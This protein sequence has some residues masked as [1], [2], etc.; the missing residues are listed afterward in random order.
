[1]KISHSFLQL[2]SD[3]G[4]QTAP[5]PVSNPQLLLW[6]AELA[7]EL[8][9]PDYLNDNAALFL[10]G[11]Q[12]LPGSQPLAQAYAGHQF[13]SYNPAL[14]DG[15]AHLIAELEAPSGQTIDLQ[16]KGSGQTR[17][18][19]RGDGRC[20]IGPAIREF[21]MSEAMH[22]LGV[23]TTRTLAV[24]TSGETVLR[25]TPQAGAIVSRVADSHLRVGTF[26]YHCYSGNR[27]NL[28]ALLDYTIQRHYPEIGTDDDNRAIALLKAVIKKQIELVVEWMRVGFI[29]GV[30]N[31]DNTALSGQTIDFGPCAMLGIY[32][33]NTAYSAIDSYGR[34][35]FG[36]QPAIT[37][38]NLA[39]FAESLLPLIDP[40]NEKALAQAVPIIEGFA[41]QYYQA[42]YRMMAGKLGLPR[43]DRQLTD[44]LLAEMEQGQ[45]D[46][47]DTFIKLMQAVDSGESPYGG[48][49][50]HWF[51]RWQKQLHHNSLA[52][53][54]RYN[55]LV[56]PRNHHMERVIAD[57]S[58]NNSSAAADAFL[59]V[60]R[61]PYKLTPQTSAYQDLPADGDRNYQTFCGT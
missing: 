56:I 48:S 21:I 51:A 3:F 38:W 52:T 45:L 29:H 49:F 22:A 1:M 36:N 61:Q 40:D 43:S 23:P 28:A 20:A 4:Q 27:N 17:Y 39:R 16:L 15:R 59:Q 26:E 25:D 6:N 7:S 58:E 12:L 46:Y 41:D 9:L 57:C 54:Q 34:Y 44:Q 37:Q 53:M 14:G 24:V 13:G 19:R 11:N 18:S 31:T 5:I 8:Q 42:F 50:A 10:S 35:C 60:L 2:G 30:M 33:P 55:P 47:T 32:Q